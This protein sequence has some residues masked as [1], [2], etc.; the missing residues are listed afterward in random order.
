MDP[1]CQV[2]GT[3]LDESGE[4]VRVC[5][6]CKRGTHEECWS[7]LGGC[8]DPACRKLAKRPVDPGLGDAAAVRRSALERRRLAWIAAQETR[9]AREYHPLER[10]LFSGAAACLVVAAGA[11]VTDSWRVVQ[12]AMPAAILLIGLA[13][14]HRGQRRR[15]QVH[16]WIPAGSAPDKGVKL[17]DWLL[18]VEGEGRG[19]ETQGF[20]AEYLGTD[21]LKRFFEDACRG[22]VFRLKTVGG[23]RRVVLGPRGEA[24]LEEARRRRAPSLPAAAES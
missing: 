18:R 14:F 23:A 8:I 7:H 2:C 1:S 17:A 22:D 11:E 6:T 20:Q 5:P 12:L 3:V 13:L 4:G 21:E 16:R 19:V 15:G 10:G 9:L 24:F